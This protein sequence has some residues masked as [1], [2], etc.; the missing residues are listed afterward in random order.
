MATIQ[1]YIS[2]YLAQR[3]AEGLSLVVYDREQ[4]Y[5]DIVSGLAGDDCVVIDA[6][7]STI[8]GREQAIDTWK[9]MA[10]GNDEKHLIIY[11]PNKRPVRDEEKQRNP[12]QIFEIGGGRFPESDGESYQALCHKAAPEQVLKIDQLFAAGTPD[13][14]TI[15]NL[16]QGGSNWPKLRTILKAESATEIVVSLL[17]PSESAKTSLNR[18]ETWVPEVKE[19]L[20]STLQLQLKTK[21]KKWQSISDELWRYILYSEFVFDLPGELPEELKDVPRGPDFCKDVVYTICDTLRGTDRHQESYMEAAR[22]TV[23]ELQLLERVKEIE[24]LG[25]RDTFEFE[26]RTFVKRFSDAVLAEQYAV[27]SD[28]LKARQR[29]IWVRQTTE[30]QA[31]WT[32]ADW[33][34]QLI[35][36]TADIRDVLNKVGKNIA[37]LFNFY[38]D[39]FRQ[40][41]RLHRNLERAVSDTLGELENLERLIEEA[42]EQYLKVAET[43]QA[44]FI[45]GVN[46]EGWPVSGPLRNNDVFE[47]F[48]A[49]WLKDRKMT[50][51]FMVD[52][53]RYELAAELEADI[54]EKYKTQFH[55]VCAQLPTVTSV[56]MASLLPAVNGYMELQC[57]SGQ[58]VP[59]IKDTKVCT[60]QER[61]AYVQSI[62]GERVE[63]IDLDKLVK[64]RKIK[65]S[66]KTNLLLVKT[67]DIDAFGETKPYDALMLLPRI[68]GK[69]IVGI[70]RLEKMGF[71]RVVIGTDH[72]FIL[73]HD[74]K[75]G[76]QVPKPPGE[77]QVSK[78]RC[79]LGTGS[80]SPGIAVFKTDDVSISSTC[81]HYAVPKTFGT[82]SK[83]KPY[84]HQGLSLQECVLPVICVELTGV[85]KPG[86]AKVEVQLSYKGG[87][88]DKI[89]SRR[90][91][92]EVSAFSQTD[93]FGSAEEI[94]FQLEAYSNKDVVGEAASCPHLN[95]SNNLVRI[96]PGQAIKIP[97]RMQEDFTGTFEVRAINPE[98]MVNYNTIKLKTDYME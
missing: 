57:E 1:E 43:L 52:A 96:K 35:I 3:V 15:N 24:D 50:A 78:E 68:M 82:F 31:I 79:L 42:R 14:A 38:T 54:S 28:I 10:A 36:Q 34:S 51:L 95:P 6:S 8:L 64:Q 2:N 23:E 69:V 60:P 56:G 26:E 5:R 46:G 41:D 22:R 76:D 87:K 90:P 73:I 89:T 85:R 72:G 29:S 97:L 59:V 20:Q 92:I 77:W 16:I 18:D 91:M 93:L 19:F 49:P 53:L 11:L 83:T 13:F 17:S 58:I 63:M 98:T 65:L 94:E 30:R 80:P 61:L 70:S 47:K 74:Q 66:D 21:G 81:S 25:E 39:R 40:I 75:A 84:F 33:A 62:Y 88:T 48:V 86:A 27:A 32:V 45:A 71:E 37:E 4:R 7:L 12:Y 55:A 67:T 9:R 44:K